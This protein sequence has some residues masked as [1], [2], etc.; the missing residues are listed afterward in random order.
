M[1]RAESPTE[2][3]GRADPLP[4]MMDEGSIMVGGRTDVK[5]TASEVVWL[6]APDFVTQLVTT[7]GVKGLVLKELA[8]DC[9]SH[10]PLQGDQIG[11]WP[12]AGAEEAL[13]GVRRRDRREPRN[14]LVQ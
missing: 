12:A 2:V 13:V 8:N 3:T 11:S 5:L 7:G 6:E 4:T 10:A 1:G 14:T 9:Y